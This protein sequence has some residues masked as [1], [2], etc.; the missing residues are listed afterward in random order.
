MDVLECEVLDVLEGGFDFEK[1][2]D[3]EGSLVVGAEAEDVEDEVDD[4]GDG[5]LG[6]CG[7]DG[8]VDEGDDFVDSCLL[9]FEGE[10]AY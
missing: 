5:V 4:L 6:G 10:D 3:D 7:D 2:E 1:G 9:D 8:G